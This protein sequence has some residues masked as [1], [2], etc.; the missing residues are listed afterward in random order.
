MSRAALFIIS[1]LL[2]AYPLGVYFGLSHLEPR[3]FG[4]LLLALVIARFALARKRLKPESQ[5]SLLP[6][7]V[8]TTALCLLILIF[9]RMSM[10]RLNPALVNLVLLLTFS[11]TLYSP[12]SMIERLAR[13]S[14]AV[15]SGP[16]VA[17]T[18]NVTK[19]W[20][21]FFIF[22]GA[23]ALYTCFFTSLETW[24]LYNG[25]IAYL[26]MGL[27]FLAEYCVR[28][29]KMRNAC[30]CSSG[31]TKSCR[32]RTIKRPHWPFIR[33]YRSDA[34]SLITTSRRCA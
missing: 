16:A 5:T 10:V 7:T 13:L 1:L 17:Y 22:N 28:Q 9:N 20:C 33:T 21:L 12:P 14:G 11:Y 30:A 3:H 2:L 27:L 8:A 18:R 32:M 31:A 24:T 19:M 34:T 23:A 25:L 4:L 29:H 15:I 6:I 26:L